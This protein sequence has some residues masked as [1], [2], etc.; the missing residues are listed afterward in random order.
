[1]AGA[2]PLDYPGL[3]PEA[4]AACAAETRG[5]AL[6]HIASQL[7]RR[8]SS[9]ERLAL[10]HSAIEKDVVPLLL[11]TSVIL[12][13]IA[14]FFCFF[15]HGRSVEEPAEEPPPQTRE[16]LQPKSMWTPPWRVARPGTCC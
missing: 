10:L 11:I 4:R 12:A 3:E 7:H 13:F 6:L 15:C 16:P 9:G 14:A 2:A 8:P 5:A 1:M